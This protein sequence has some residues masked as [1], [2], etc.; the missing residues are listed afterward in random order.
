M[1]MLQAAMAG[2]F[3]MMVF[4]G[5]LLLAG[6]PILTT[7]LMRLYRKS[8]LKKDRGKK[9]FYQDIIP[10]ISIVFF[11]IT[12]LLFLFYLLIILLDGVVPSFE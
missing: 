12:T 9:E 8:S 11:S 6:V 10:F 7:I 4:L 3:L 2:G 1:I 5:L